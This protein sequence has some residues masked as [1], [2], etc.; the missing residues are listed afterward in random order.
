MDEFMSSPSRSRCCIW[1]SSKKKEDVK[2]GKSSQISGSN[3]YYGDY[4]MEENIYGENGFLP[5]KDQER[6]LKEAMKE[7]EKATKKVAKKKGFNFP[8][9]GKGK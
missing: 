9:K 4:G 8:V 2:G 5:V 6:L 3:F 7:Q 1:K